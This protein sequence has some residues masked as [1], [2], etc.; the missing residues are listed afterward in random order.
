MIEK[1]LLWLGSVF[2][3]VYA[4]TLTLSPAA[5]MHSWQ[6]EYRWDHWLGLGIWAFFVWLGHF[7]LNKRLAE[8]DMY[9]YPLAAVLSGWG[10]MTIWRLLPEFGMRQ[11]AWLAAGLAMLILGLRLPTGLGLLYRFKYVWL[12]SGLLLTAATLIL[13]TNPQG[14]GA[15]LWLGCC[16]L[17]MQ[18]SEILKL[19]LIIYLAA[20]FSDRFKKESQSQKNWL[21]LLTPTLIL[22]GVAMLLLVFQRDLGTAS[23]FLGLYAALLYTATG[24]NWLVPLTGLALAVAIAVGY[25]VF[26]VVQLRVNAWLNPWLDPSGRSYQIV[27]SIMAIAS[28][29]LFGQGIGMGSPGLVP[30]AHSDFIFAAIAEE[31]GLV[32]ALG[33]LLILGLLVNHGIRVALQASTAFQRY[34]AAGITAH[35]AGQSIL[36]IGG[37]LRLLPLTGVTLPFVSYGGSSLVTSLLEILLLLLISSQ[38]TQES[39]QV[40]NPKPFKHLAGILLLGLG[41]AGLVTGWWSVWRGPDLVERTDN[42]RRSINDRYVLRGAIL[43]QEGEALSISRGESGSYTRFYDYPYLGAI[44]GYTN[45]IYGQAGLEASL[46]DYLRGLQGN[47]QRAVWWNH[48]AYGQPPPGLDVRLSLILSLQEKADDLL[49]EHSGAIVLINA[50]SGEILALASHPNFD[51]NRLE[52]N[53]ASIINDPQAPL[54]NRTTLGQYPTGAA[55]GGLLLAAQT[56]PSNL[57]G[58]ASVNMRDCTL[59][60][61]AYVWGSMLR[62]GCTPAVEALGNRLGAERLEEV[63][64]AA[65]FYQA[66]ELRLDTTAITHEQT[67]SNAGKMALGLPDEVSDEHLLVSPLQMA[68]A[69]ASLSNGGVRPAPRLAVAVNT[70]QS[71]WVILPPLGEG[72]NVFSATSAHEAS[73]MLAVPKL[74][75]WQLTA[76]AWDAEGNPYTWHLAGTQPS[77]PGAPLTLVVLIEED[78][79][80]LAVEIGETLLNQAM[81]P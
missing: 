1:R 32:G 76:R 24:K 20:Y 22:T 12:S 42:V 25:A 36:I 18:P 80:L 35:L 54:I 55:L 5:R 78:N 47:P 10:M 37:N 38:G 17:Y 29:G 72:E 74:P 73:Q 62:A 16:G 59:E 56:D 57:P 14:T 53:W 49:G 69:A 4:L 3:G 68:L 51:A 66:P 64:N 41:A 50:Q 75:A 23:I 44:L 19:L 77:W 27:Q 6:A 52:E 11:A 33:L 8:R 45:P 46:D 58:A 21:P 13:G 2:L 63:F 60:P 48:L 28:G 39:V 70:P 40:Y 65:G 26:D 34:L 71:G 15:Q 30:V 81:H 7:Q 31:S 61:S 9:F 79:P 43:S 67:W